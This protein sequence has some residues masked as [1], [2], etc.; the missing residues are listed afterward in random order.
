MRLS[1][2]TT[3]TRDI[4]ALSSTARRLLSCPSQPLLPLEPDAVVFAF[5]ILLQCNHTM[6]ISVETARVLILMHI[7]KHLVKIKRWSMITSFIPNR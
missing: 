4:M 1:F 5:G 2:R 7:K 6:V 3:L